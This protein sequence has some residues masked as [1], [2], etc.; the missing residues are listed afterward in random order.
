M[1]LWCYLYGTLT[2]ATSTWAQNIRSIATLYNK[3][4]TCACMY[5]TPWPIDVCRRLLRL[6]VA[7]AVIHSTA[8]YHQRFDQLAE[9]AFVR[10]P[11]IDQLVDPLQARCVLWST[12]VAREG[13]GDVWVPQTA[14]NRGRSQTPSPRWKIRTIEI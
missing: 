10:H 3:T 4:V 7:R 12:W 5:C 6:G 9:R 13:N 2:A 8:V 14:N 11:C 1:P